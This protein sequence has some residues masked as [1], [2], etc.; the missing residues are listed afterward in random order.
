MKPLVATNIKRPLVS[1]PLCPEGLA[2]I[3]EHRK[4]FNLQP[5]DLINFRGRPHHLQ[6][7]ENTHLTLVGTPGDHP[8]M[9]PCLL[10]YLHFDLLANC[11]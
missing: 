2:G 10:T 11:L 8:S 9:D 4:G 6:I 1:K 7:V 5:T 3:S